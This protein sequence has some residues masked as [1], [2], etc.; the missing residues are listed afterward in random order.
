MFTEILRI[1]PVLDASAAKGMEKSLTSR[2]SSIAKKF[3]GGLKSALKGSLFGISL[4]FLNKIL[5]P[6]EDLEKK[7]KGLLEQGTELRDLADEFG[8]NSGRVKQLQDVAS[9]FGVTPEQLKGMLDKFSEAVNTARK[10][11]E[12]PTATISDTTRA[13]A[14][15]AQEK[16]KIQGFTKF[17]S[18][19]RQTGKGAGQ[20]VFFGERE[21]RR[22]AERQAS[23]E[24]LSDSER[25]QLQQQGLVKHLSGKDLRQSLEEK[26]FGSAQT[27]A[28]ARLISGNFG[29]R[30]KQ[31]NE[32]DVKT[33]NEKS[34][35]LAS[36]D[37]QK[38]F[39]ETVNQT[40]DFLASSDKITPGVVKS[41]TDAEAKQNA[42]DVSRI[43]DFESL[44]NAATSIE[45]IKGGLETVVTKA[46]LVVGALADIQGTLQKAGSFFRNWGGGSKK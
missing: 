7:I 16:D 6:I 33:L 44:R 9:S 23:G 41:I 27:G 20:D 45:E 46:T 19:L 8:S 31:L 29:E 30:L 22:A 13:I 25:Q 35:K 34:N 12:D 28:S 38:R 36:L 1:K 11:I 14:P 43:D 3:G 4:G 5:N 37:D 32:P 39:Q 18:S 2:F 26:V 15:F 40:K 24:K 42:K 10:E 17:L 21:Q